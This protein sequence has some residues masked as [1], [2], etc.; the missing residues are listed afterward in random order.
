MQRTDSP[1]ANYLGKDMPGTG[2]VVNKRHSFP[3]NVN[4][5]VICSSTMSVPLLGGEESGVCKLL[6]KCLSG[7][8]KQAA[9]YLEGKKRFP[10]EKN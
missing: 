7:F 1:L 3:L 5:H 4:Y 10:K 9:I 8:E 6:F 2:P